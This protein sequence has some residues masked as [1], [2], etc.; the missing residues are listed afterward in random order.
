MRK[1]F[2]HQAVLITFLLFQFSNCLAAESPDPNDPNRYLNA[3][4]TFADNMLK[5]GRDTYGPKHT[6]LFVDG[7][8][9]HTH[10]PVRWIA[11]NGDRWIL[12]NFACQ[13]NL[14]RTLD[15][16]TKITGDPNYKKA[17]MD[18][19]R[20]AFDNLR[21]PNGLLYWGAGTAYDVRA[22]RSAGTYGQAG[23]SL[24]WHYPYYE[25]MWQ[26]NSEAA[27]M[28]IESFWSAHIL[29]WS[30]LDMNRTGYFDD[31]L[32]EPWNHVYEGGA[33]FFES[34]GLSFINTGSDL[35][36][37]AAMLSKLSGEKQP[38]IWGKRL[39]HRY[40]ETRVPNVGIAG[41]VYTQ[42]KIP[43]PYPFGDDFK[44][45]LVLLGTL[46]PKHPGVGNP[47]IRQTLLGELIVSPGIAGD[48]FIIPWI[49][50]FL[51][52]DT[53]G[54]DGK[55]FTQWALEEL[56][57]RGKIAYRKKDNSFIPMFT[58][59]T[60]LE[61]YVCK[62]DS[63]LGPKG[64]VFMP[65]R[66]VSMDFWAYAIAY[67]ITGDG[68]MWEMARNIALGHNYGDIGTSA[69]DELRVETQTDCSDP[70]ALLGF[71]ELHK[72][73]GKR[74]L[75]DIAV[76]IGDNI[77]SS[78]V[79]KGFFVPSGKHIYA[80]FDTIEPLVLLHLHT[81]LNKK[82]FL[83]PQVW[84]NR[85]YFTSKYRGKE[86]AIDNI[87]IYALTESSEP[88]MSLQ[89]AAAIGD[90]DLVRSII[91]KGTKVD[92][93]EDSFL[94]T[95]LHRASISGHTNV[96]ELLLA[97][98]ADV[99]A[100]SGWPGGTSL[101]YAADNGH[102]EIAELLIARGANINATRRYPAGDTPLHSAVRAGH[103][104]IVELL[105]TKGANVTAKNKAGQTP[106][107]IAV[108]QKNKEIVELLRKHG[109]KE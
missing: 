75:L 34:S 5:Y 20:Y 95:A 16:L 37:A 96:V 17:A 51:L 100:N 26:V 9:I 102:K 55:E 85:S 54:K 46:F 19:I 94:K 79:H 52:G 58:D 103:K 99:N 18:A 40:V 91:E 72:K 63:S 10:E 64:T 31:A 25:L 39:A 88:P 6:P 43:E 78:R 38:L 44:G 2:V 101:H 108:R 106:L 98:G 77:L 7:L 60:T 67:R 27:M 57:A 1:R 76:R 47:G 70:Y 49:C 107:D 83:V 74:A 12:C 3:V 87:V 105:I 62:K 89:E 36:Y 69:K 97:N 61:G 32:E 15:G 84:P 11:P 104:D 109:A 33:V 65:I 23:H 4:R 90:I 93:R 13:Q 73:T 42:S 24:K 92:A 21:S 50:Q 59:G 29:H 8:N 68:F 53:L 82:P 56:T 45:H 81:T 41:Y 28:F 48:V 71:L 35:F 14:M 30:N 80:K 22:D 66:A 86:N